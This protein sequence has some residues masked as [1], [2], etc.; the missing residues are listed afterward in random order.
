MSAI[1]AASVRETYELMKA[2]LHKVVPDVELVLKAELVYEINRLKVEKDAIILGHNYMEPALFHTIPDFVGDSLALSRM[3]AQTEKSIIISTHILEEVDAICTRA[4]VISGGRV[5]AD[6]TPVELEQ[7]SRHYNA[8]AVRLE[9]EA[10]TD[11]VKSA[12]ERI[13]GALSVEA[14][15]YSGLLTVYPKDGASLIGEVGQVMRS[16]RWRVAEIRVERGHLDEVF[17]RITQA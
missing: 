2:K 13:D 11:A 7:L 3:A 8:V 12:L 1:Q 15:K 9:D 6:G 14:N 17:R 10:D 4:M 16:G 5:V